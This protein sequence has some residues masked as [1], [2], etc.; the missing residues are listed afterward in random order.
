MDWIRKNKFMSGL[1]AVVVIGAGVLIYLLAGQMSTYE[2]VSQDYDAA[3][4]EVQ[5]LDALEPYPEQASQKKLEDLRKSTATAVT[6][7]QTQ[8]AAYEPP[9][10]KADFK[11][12]DFQDKL[13]RV[14]DEVT[15]A[16]QAARVELPKDFYM[17]FE[18]YRGTPP[19]VAA[20]P[21]LSRELDAIQDLMMV[22]IG[23]RIEALASIKRSPLP[24][25][26]G[27]NTAS[28]TARTGPGNKPGAAPAAD[29]VTRSSVTVAF[30]CQPSSFRDAL[31]EFVTSKRLFLVRAVDV[32]NDVP[33]GPK[34]AVAPIVEAAP[35][36]AATTGA[37]ETNPTE[38]APAAEKP[39]LRYI[40]GLE[41]LSVTVRIEIV[42][43]APAAL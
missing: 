33:A 29:S 9:P 41:G 28:T 36:P 22:L 4:K 12:I 11:P 42:K 38:T 10:E 37:A 20:A 6:A 1:I 39:A 15:Q 21:V 17:G 19:E 14:V 2:Q 16:A 3:V 18:Q 24:Q 40:V 26:T 7:L 5:R 13:R 27:G 8:L 43:V 23:K 25:E 35:T 32:K 30:K 34:K 31:D